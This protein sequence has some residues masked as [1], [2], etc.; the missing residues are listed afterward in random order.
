ML[1]KILSLSVILILT[2]CAG[3]QFCDDKGKP[4]GCHRWDPATTTGA[5]NR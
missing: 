2:G 1:K 3:I 5:A 4:P